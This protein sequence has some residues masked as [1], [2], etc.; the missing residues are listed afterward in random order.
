MVNEIDSEEDNEMTFRFKI[1]AIS[2][3]SRWIHIQDNSDGDEYSSFVYLVKYLQGKGKLLCVGEVQYRIEEDPFE[4][5]YQWDSCFGIVVIYKHK[6][7]I[8]S[9]LSFLQRHIDELNRK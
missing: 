1:S 6:D 4:L 8:D 2:E 5:V 7:D 3:K 9:V